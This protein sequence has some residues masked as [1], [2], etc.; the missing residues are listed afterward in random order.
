MKTRT[1]LLLSVGTALMILIAGGVLLVQ[2]SGQDSTT[3]ASPLGVEVRVGDVDITVV[4]AE[5]D[6]ALLRVLVDVGGVADPRGIESLSLVTGD[7]R[8]GAV[9]APAD[10]RCAEI[11][12]MSQRCSI[13]FDVS[14]SEGTSRVLIMVRGEAQATW[15]LA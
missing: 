10:E 4:G 5:R 11:T 2:L 7:Q 1:L 9:A 14:A 12:E 15:R 13:D 6:G 8:L 3:E